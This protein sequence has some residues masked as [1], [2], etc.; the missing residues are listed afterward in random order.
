VQTS[1]YP[2][3]DPDV[4]LW[5]HG[6][7]TGP[8]DV[9]VIWRADL[10][11]ALLA[12]DH[13][14]LA[15]SLVTACRPGSREAMSVPLHAVRGW[16]ASKVRDGAGLPDAVEVT[17]L[18]G[19]APDGEAAGS[20]PRDG[21]IM[22]VL[23]WRGDQSE[24][25]G[26]SREI[27]PGD[28]LIV[29]AS[30][31]GIAAGNWAPD[32]KAAVRDWGHRAQVELLRRAVLRLDRA[33]FDAPVPAETAA[34]SAELLIR[35]TLPLV[36][37]E[38]DA[39]DA[40]GDRRVVGEWLDS[41][42]AD[43]GDGDAGYLTTIVKSLRADAKRSVTRAV[44]ELDPEGSPAREIFIV[45]S[46]KALRP[47]S[48]DVDLE[49]ETSS[50]T[51][52]PVRLRRHLRDV[53]T[54]A[55]AFA[56]SCRLPEDLASDLQLAGRLHD[57]GK[58]D[59][60]FQDMLWYEGG[61]GNRVAAAEP[62]AKS[63]VA[64]SDRAGRERARRASGYPRGGRHELLSVAM[65]TQPE[66]WAARAHDWDL[67]LHLVASHHGFC[68]PFAPVVLDDAPPVAAFELDGVRM[69]HSSATGL[70]RV[71]S[72]VADRF[73]LLVERYGWFGLTWLESILRLADHRASAWE[74]ANPGEITKE[75]PGE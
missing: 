2:D 35:D 20:S 11:A 68:R 21:H 1:P 17:D 24:V 12:K 57:I 42:P 22:P 40:A 15:V 43:L 7:D 71:D 33:V 25:T 59:P 8:A 14:P 3:A 37:G 9:T 52:E 54:W 65:I 62:L 36:P 18:E 48:G 58:A 45:T 44:T 38:P 74:Q 53:G 32:A 67:V 69:E 66:K 47:A 27:L 10:N 28:T 6:P 63:R 56:L 19:A 60:R 16:L 39:D 26:D 5:L 46:S 51:G 75:E 70:A 13:Q 50:F 29:P 23:R 41:L 64:A 73:W 31:G 72:G 4:A 55:R 49:A 61:H 34:T 30:Y